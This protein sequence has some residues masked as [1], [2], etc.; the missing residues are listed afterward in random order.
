[1]RSKIAVWKRIL[2]AAH[3]YQFPV[4]P[5]QGKWSEDDWIRWIDNHGEWLPNGG[6]IPYF[7]PQWIRQLGCNLKEDKKYYDAGTKLDP[8]FYQAASRSPTF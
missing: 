3:L 8:E 4:P 6:R 7:M 1:M 5:V 2:Y